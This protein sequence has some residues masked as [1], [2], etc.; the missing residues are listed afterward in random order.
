MLTYHLPRSIDVSRRLAMRFSPAAVAISILLFLSA[1]HSVPSP[2]PKV[3]GPTYNGAE[4]LLRLKWLDEKGQIPRDGLLKAQEQIRRMRAAQPRE[5]AAGINRSGWTWLGPGNIGGRITTILVH[6]TDPNL[7]W[8]N[9]PG[10]GIWKTTNAGTTW[11]PVNDFL[12]NLAVS[13]LAIS[14][15]DTNTMH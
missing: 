1:C 14:P 15:T 3:H 11:Q 2:R 13:A 12:G 4:E 10:G 7:M 5:D 8:V 9:N 6:P